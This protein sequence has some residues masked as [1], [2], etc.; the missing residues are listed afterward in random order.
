MMPME[1]DMRQKNNIIVSDNDLSP[2]RRQAIIWANAGMLLFG[3]WEETTV[4]SW[5]KFIYFHSRPCIWKCRLDNVGIF[6]SFPM[7]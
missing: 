2:G 3:T 5:L 6:V 7:C 1:A 4:K